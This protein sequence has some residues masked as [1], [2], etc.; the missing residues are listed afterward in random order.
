MSWIVGAGSV[1]LGAVV[2]ASLE[3]GAEEA[4]A[5]AASEPDVHAP[6]ASMMTN[7]SERP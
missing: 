1:S 6:S 5:S 4:G 2:S 3:I 7:A